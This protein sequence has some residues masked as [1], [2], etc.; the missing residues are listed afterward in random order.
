MY[1]LR[2]S[3]GGYLL[4]PV[5]KRLRVEL[6]MYDTV[7]LFTVRIALPQANTKPKASAAAGA[8]RR[9][10]SLELHQHGRWLV[11]C[12]W[13]QTSRT[14]QYCTQNKRSSEGT[15]DFGSFAP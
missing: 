15:D 8:R 4:L 6:L 9:E 13:R 12:V 2:A 14:T 1:V 10:A 7:V 5:R 3:T 11:L